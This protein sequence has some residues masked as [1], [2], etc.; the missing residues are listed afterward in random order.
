MRHAAIRHDTNDTLNFMEVSY[1]REVRLACH[2]EPAEGIIRR[3]LEQ[4][5]TSAGR[6]SH[7]ERASAEFCLPQRRFENSLRS[8]LVSPRVPRYNPHHEKESSMAAGDCNLPRLFASVLAA[9]RR[10]KL[11][12]AG[13]HRHHG[14]QRGGCSNWGDSSRSSGDYREEPDYDGWI[15]EG[16]ALSAQRADHSERQRCLP[17]SGLVGHACTPGIRRLVSPR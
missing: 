5:K 10:P 8:G 9:H 17:D 4:P 12:A 1:F 3:A 13:H 7:L 15:E 11:V 6:L 16:H 14:C 2:P